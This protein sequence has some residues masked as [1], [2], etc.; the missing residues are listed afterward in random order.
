MLDG[1][2]AKN[3]VGVK[4]PISEKGPKAAKAKTKNNAKKAAPSKTKKA[5]PTKTKKVVVTKTKKT[6]ALLLP[7]PG[8]PSRAKEPVAYKSFRI[9]SDLNMGS[10]RTKLSV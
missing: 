10:W 5:T 7:F 6:A 1:G 3:H 9:Y 2:V 8:V 4:R